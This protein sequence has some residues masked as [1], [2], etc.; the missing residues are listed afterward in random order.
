MKSIFVTQYSL[1][2]DP[3]TCL[4][5]Q[6]SIWVGYFKEPLH[7]GSPCFRYIWYTWYIFDI[8]VISD[9]F[10][11]VV[12]KSSF[13]VCRPVSKIFDIR[14]IFDI[15]DTFEIVVL[16][17]HFTVGCPVFRYTW[18]IFDI[19]EYIWYIRYIWVSCFK[20]PVGRPVSNI[21]DIIDIYLIHPIHLS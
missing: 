21:F 10:E 13:T 5:L 6:G 2:I 7:G 4:V 15:S 19:F 18:Y 11:L 8:F 1:N 12:L 16:K 3:S 14:D 20:E 17:C 9:T